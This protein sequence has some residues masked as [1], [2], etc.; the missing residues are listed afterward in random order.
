MV[1]GIHYRFM[2]LQAVLA[3]G[4]KIPLAVA[5]ERLL[6]ACQQKG[7]ERF[8]YTST[9]SVTFSIGPI[10]G[11]D[12][13]LPYFEENLSPY[14][15]TKALAEQAVLGA[16]QSNQ[17]RTLA[18]RPHLIWGTGDPHLLPRVISSCVREL[19]KSEKEKT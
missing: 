4:T 11:G 1:S 3:E 5:T 12:E 14:A 2:W 7:V 16:D 9:P 8:I 17:M 19:K 10:R 18:L 6:Q 15:S 13:S